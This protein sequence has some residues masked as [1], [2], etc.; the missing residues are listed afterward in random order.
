MIKIKIILAVLIIFSSACVF[1]SCSDDDEVIIK[2]TLE[3]ETSE[4]I[5]P[6]T[7][8][9]FTIG[10][11]A[12]NEYTVTV[13]ETGT[14]WL[15]YEIIESGDSLK[16]SY[17]QNDSTLVRK[18]RL[19]I[20][21]DDVMRFLYVEQDGFP[22]SSVTK[23][24]LNYTVTTGGGY[25]ILSVPDEDC[26][27]IPIGSTIV[28]ECGESGSISFLDASYAEFAGGV[29]V[30]GTF[31]FVW[32]QE[33]ANITAG[34][35]ITTGVLRD[36]F[37]ISGAYALYSKTSLEYTITSGGGYTI[38]SVT[39][40]ECEKIPVGA[41]VNFSCPSDDGSISLL[42]ATYTQYAGGSPVNGK[43]SFG[44]T[45]E[46]ATITAEGGISTG[47][48]RDG[49]D[50]SSLFF[51]DM[52]TDLEYS[53]VESGG[54]TIF[55]VSL[56]ECAKI[57]I[58]ATVVLECPSDAGTISLLDATYTEYAGGSP[59]NGEFSF[60]WTKEIATITAASG[61]TTGILRDGFDVSGMH[62]H[63]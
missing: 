12:N 35:G 5:V 47:V 2:A 58:G 30:D 15:T 60:I 20:I 26:D 55:S 50:I 59:V 49:F 18:S 24:D 36:G 42:D 56:E 6:Y 43:F 45:N 54:Y 51:I 14:D 8:G 52:N 4:T 22:S 3:L 13:D 1:T 21:N 61:I 38:F 33:I 23:V 31:S 39:A 37:E 16:V 57:P 27:Q 32:T 9:S 40:E 46:I 34:S 17:I 29:P 53:I 48:I 7:T 10:V 41:T 62:C 25:T 44:W 63:N 19:I 28:F 11:S